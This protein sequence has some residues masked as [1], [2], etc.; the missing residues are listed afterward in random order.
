MKKFIV[1]TLV[2]LSL[3]ALTVRFSSFVPQFLGI[4]EK[5]GISITSNPDGATVT[6]D[7]KKVG[8]TPYVSDNLEPKEYRVSLEKDGSIWQGKVRLTE[9]TLL[10]VNR[11]L[12][13]DPTSSAGESLT[14]DKGKGIIV[15]AN[16]PDS[17][18]EIDGKEYGKTP[19]NLDIASGEHNI[20]ITHPNYLKRNISAKL[21]E[22][23]NLVVS[24]DLPISDVDLTTFTAPTITETKEVIVKN[25]PVGFLR[26]R[27]KPSLLGKEIARLNIG[28]T[29]ILLSEEGSWD[30]IRLESGLEGYVSSTYVEKKSSQ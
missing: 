1:W 12:S 9:N 28:D 14:L 2:L 10:L 11:D 4:K 3:L 20:L 27:D 25:T 6:I 29:L 13:K 15:I 18:I 24:V 8:K 5:S 16:P 7:G 21:P 19:K 23:F 26:V 22:G 30:R 17:D